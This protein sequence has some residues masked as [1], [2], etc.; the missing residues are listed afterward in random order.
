MGELPNV[1]YFEPSPETHN[2]YNLILQSWTPSWVPIVLITHVVSFD[3]LQL[4]YRFITTL[5][6][7]LCLGLLSCFMFPDGP[8][9]VSFGEFSFNLHEIIDSS[10]AFNLVHKASELPCFTSHLL[11]TGHQLA[12]RKTAI[13]WLRWLVQTLY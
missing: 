8:R 10:F 5:L 6:L 4:Q 9:Q 12:Q 2:I 13:R 7:S 3:I 1:V 11:G